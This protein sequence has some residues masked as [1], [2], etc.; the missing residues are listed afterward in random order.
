MGLLCVGGR[1]RAA[2]LVATQARVSP[3]AQRVGGAVERL[4]RPAAGLAPVD[5][6][7]VLRAPEPRLVVLRVVARA[8]LKRR[9]Q[10]ARVAAGDVPAARLPPLAALHR[11]TADGGV[12]QVPRPPEPRPVA[13]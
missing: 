6:D 12:A 5:A 11:Q 7:G 8:L 13:Q 1:A 2:A 3:L 4:R 10:R 9:V